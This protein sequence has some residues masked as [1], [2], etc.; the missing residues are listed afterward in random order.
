[1]SDPVRPH[2]EQLTRLPCPWDS[3]GKNTGVGCHFLVQCVKSKTEV[4]QSC[5]TLSDP[6]DCSLL[7]SSVHGIFQAKA[8]EWLSI[9]FRLL[10]IQYVCSNKFL[11]SYWQYI[12]SSPFHCS[13]GIWVHH[14]HWIKN[15]KPLLLAENTELGFWVLLFSSSLFTNCFRYVSISECLN[16][17]NVTKK[18][19]A[20]LTRFIGKYISGTWDFSLHTYW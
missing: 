13:L 16:E 9:A 18:K 19:G 7:G 17:D 4:I 8:L 12:V 10:L 14:T 15:L 2:R 1:M 3:P 5:L 6:M 20:T 11:S